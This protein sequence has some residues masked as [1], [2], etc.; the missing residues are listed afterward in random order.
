MDIDTREE[1]LKKRLEQL[2][3]L[4]EE[5]K[6]REKAL[7]NTEAAKKQILLR[8][9]PTLWAQ[10]AQWAEDDFRSINSQIEYI[11]SEAVKKRGL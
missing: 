4:E 7:K 3:I 8:L 11:L 6:M 2:K 9:A 5:I 1:M 10:I